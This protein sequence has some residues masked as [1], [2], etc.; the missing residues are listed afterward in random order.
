MRPA[1]PST[2]I[3][4]MAYRPIHVTPTGPDAINAGPDRRIQGKCEWYLD[5]YSD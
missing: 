5:L 3:M 1:A 2:T 4:M